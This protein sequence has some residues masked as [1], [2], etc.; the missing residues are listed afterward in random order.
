MLNQKSILIVDDN[1]FVALDLAMA[2]E[3][4]NGC[5]LGPVGT[6]AEALNLIET[7]PVCGAVVDCQL[8]DSCV[9]PLVG[10]LVEKGVPIVMQTDADIPAALS[11][12]YPDLPVLRRPIQPS[13]VLEVLVD[14]MRT[15][16]KF[17]RQDV[18]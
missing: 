9:T 18:T 7:M 16:D 1:A 12:S 13:T 11:Q 2:V 8:A 15:T 4:L 10:A 14:I 6:V 17:R 5:V 3:G